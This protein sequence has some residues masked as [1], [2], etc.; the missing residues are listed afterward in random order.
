MVFRWY[1]FCSNSES[2]KVGLSIR[3][4]LTLLK[5]AKKSSL[6]LC[7]MLFPYFIKGFLYKVHGAFVIL[8]D[9]SLF[10]L[11]TNNQPTAQWKHFPTLA[12]NCWIPLYL[13]HQYPFYT[14]TIEYGICKYYQYFM[15][16]FYWRP[17]KSRIFSNKIDN[18]LIK[19]L[20]GAYHFLLFIKPIGNCA[21][22]LYKRNFQFSKY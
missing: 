19:Y 6:S 5:M 3:G 16:A 1:N 2:G 4:S 14:F 15:F 10:M 7:T 22:V 18:N 21:T 8:V 9:H 13:I 11:I 20:A 17:Q 12:Y